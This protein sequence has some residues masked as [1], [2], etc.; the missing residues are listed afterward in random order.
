MSIRLKGGYYLCIFILSIPNIYFVHFLLLLLHGRH[1]E[2]NENENRPISSTIGFDF[3]GSKLYF[4]PTKLKLKTYKCSEV[5][6][7]VRSSEL[8]DERVV[9]RL[10]ESR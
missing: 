5:Q 9:K 6:P 4:R 1:T 2:E 3:V 7:T 10:N 8:P